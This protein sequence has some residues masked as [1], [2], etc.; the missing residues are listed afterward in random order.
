MTPKAIYEFFMKAPVEV[1]NE[2]LRQCYFNNN[3]NSSYIHEET[4]VTIEYDENNEGDANLCLMYPNNRHRFLYSVYLLDGEYSIG[5]KEADRD[6]IGFMVKCI[7]KH[8][9]A[10]FIYHAIG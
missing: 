8:K 5:E 1:S 4:Y 2:I 10:Q 3:P 9:L 6:E 7:R